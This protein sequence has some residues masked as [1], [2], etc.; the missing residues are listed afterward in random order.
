M[1][2]IYIYISFIYKSF[3]YT[4]IYHIF[5]NLLSTSIYGYQEKRKNLESPPGKKKKKYH[6]KKKRKGQLH[7]TSWKKS[8]D[9]QSVGQKKNKTHCKNAAMIQ[10]QECSTRVEPITRFHLNG[11]SGSLA[12]T[13]SRLPDDLL[14]WNFSRRIPT[15][16]LSWFCYIYH[17][18]IYIYI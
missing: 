5:T 8:R 3:I 17:I 13:E 14:R 2:I 10:L 9:M 12:P 4:Y 6:R 16:D 18:Y 7:H 1:C 11:S 15:C